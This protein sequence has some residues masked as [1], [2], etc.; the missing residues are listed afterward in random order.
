MSTL[1]SN[2]RRYS[3]VATLSETIHD[4]SDNKLFKFIFKIKIKVSL[5]QDKQDRQVKHRSSKL[6]TVKQSFHRNEV[7]R[8]LTEI[9]I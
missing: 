8:L 5:Q 4:Y 1:N 6:A 7:K 9:V 3:N 2:S